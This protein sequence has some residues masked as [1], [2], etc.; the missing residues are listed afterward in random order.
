MSSPIPE[1]GE[2]FDDTNP[3]V[4]TV[5]TICFAEF[6]DI[7]DLNIHLEQMHKTSKSYTLIACP[8]CESAYPDCEKFCYHLRDEHLIFFKR[9]KYC[10][11]IFTDARKQ[12]DHEKKHKTSIKSLV[13]CSQCPLTFT[14]TTELQSH[15][16][17][18]HAKNT[19]G[20]VLKAFYSHLASVLNI[21]FTTFLSNIDTDQPFHCLQCNFNSY[22]MYAY[23]KHLQT[24]EC[25]SIAC[26]DCGNIYK[27]RK[28]LQNH[29]NK[30]CSNAKGDYVVCQECKKSLKKSV[31]KEHAKKCKIF[32]CVICNI[33][34]DTMVQLSNHQSR[35]HPLSIEIKHCGLCSR[36]CVGTLALRKHIERTH[37]DDFHLY[38]YMCK[39]C[40]EVFKHPQKLFAHY[41][42]K[43]KEL[44]P[45][46]CKICNQKFR[47]RKKFTLHIKLNHKSVGFVEFDE[48]YH[49][50]FIETKSDNPFI[51]TSLINDESFGVNMPGI[52]TLLK[53]S[54]YKKNNHKTNKFPN[55]DKSKSNTVKALRERVNENSE[56][57]LTSDM[58]TETEG[59]IT[60]GNTT[61]VEPKPKLK[62]KYK[63]SNLPSKR[64]KPDDYIVLDTSEDDEPLLNLKN[65][66]PRKKKSFKNDK[67]R[68]TCD[69]CN[70]YCYT[71]QNYHNHMS[72]HSKNDVHTCIKCSRVF[73]SNTE[74]DEHMKAE[75]SSSKLTE[76]LKNILEKRRMS[77]RTDSELTLSEKFQRTIKKVKLDHFS[78]SAKIKALENGQS[79]KNFIESFT[80]EER[81]EKQITIN[82][83]VIVRAINTPFYRQPVIKMKKF[84]AKEEVTTTKLAMPVKCAR[85]NVKVNVTVKLVQGPVQSNFFIGTEEPKH[86]DK[87][88]DTFNDN[89]ESDI[90]DTT[91]IIPDVAGEVMIENEEPIKPEEEEEKKPVPQKIVI[92]NIPKDYKD[93]S[94]AHLLPEA[95]FFKIVKVNK[96]LEQEDEKKKREKEKLETEKIELPNGTKLVTVNPLAHLLGDAEVEE[97]M[98]PLKNKYYK[99]KQ[100]DF[101]NILKKALFDLENCPKS[102][103]NRKKNK[104]KAKA[105]E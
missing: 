28:G 60:E 9:C 80:P 22:D 1:H 4:D 50:Y 3:D 26:D 46:T 29:Y 23:I 43:H 97:V 73:K 64:T 62:R 48:N 54:K 31:Y 11:K 56:I 72:S 17:E 20:V 81:T 25:R 82:N 36:E 78:T 18:E 74:L 70:K 55:K 94:I 79:V 7:D 6:L 15:E 52:T 77:E 95:P 102:K 14:N 58:P 96:I 10:S 84:E 61:D 105:K 40:K 34:F 39:E 53:K 41:F 100:K 69:I 71:Y 75:H 76:Y 90:N 8:F 49:V 30:S 2:T 32:K 13:S 59:N 45:Y 68:F 98:K 83:S 33:I 89:Y 47:I 57:Q 51:P 42:M 21:N 67:T 91:D 87:C 12:R 101:E 19:D 92:N 5:C 99:P 65:K 24:L 27:Y 86:D 88:S 93:I 38:K 44:E 63:N 37:K 104:G 35:E 85:D 66:Q 16:F 103:Q